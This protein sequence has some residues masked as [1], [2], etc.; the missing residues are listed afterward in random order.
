MSELSRQSD[1]VAVAKGMGGFAYKS[2]N[3]FLIGVCDLVVKIPFKH[4]A[5]LEAKMND[6]PVRSNT[7]TLNL[8]PLQHKFLKDLW[9]AGA[10]SGVISFVERKTKPTKAVLII[11]F[12]KITF[13]G[14]KMWAPLDWYTWGDNWKKQIR[15]ELLSLRGPVHKLTAFDRKG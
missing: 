14:G 15:A 2:S 9:N 7:V 12:D 6:A 8:S 5:F 10:Q 13:I 11:P 4:A 1:V 3:Q